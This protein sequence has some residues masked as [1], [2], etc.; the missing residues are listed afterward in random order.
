MNQDKL[1]LQLHDINIRLWRQSGNPDLL[2]V[3]VNMMHDDHVVK[4][5]C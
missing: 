5:L 1:V 2:F 4:E 3:L